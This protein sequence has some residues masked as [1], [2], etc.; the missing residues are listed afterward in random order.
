MDEKRE[1]G[2]VIEKLVVVDISP[3]KGPISSSFLTYIDAFREINSS[4][5]SSRK[6]ADEILAKYEKVSYLSCRYI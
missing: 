3:A 4:R 2:F 6:Q 5:V 1:H